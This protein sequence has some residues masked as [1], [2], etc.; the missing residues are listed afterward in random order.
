MFGEGSEGTTR[1]GLRQGA[2][3]TQAPGERNV[4]EAPLHVFTSAPP[5]LHR[6]TENASF[7]AATHTGNSFSED[8]ENKH[9][10]LCVCRGKRVEGIEREKK[11]N[12]WCVCV[13]A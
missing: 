11:E 13:C 3:C 8:Y 9:G 2:C 5:S 7:E 6:C 1:R 12:V 10:F 4:L